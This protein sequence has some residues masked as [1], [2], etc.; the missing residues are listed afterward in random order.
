MELKLVNK[1]D[2]CFDYSNNS[3][4]YKYEYQGKYYE[5]LTNGN[6]I[7]ISPIKYCKCVDNN[8][9]CLYC[10]NK[11]IINNNLCIKCN[12]GFYEIEN[13]NNTNEY[14]ECYKDKIGYYLDM[15]ESIYKK[16]YFSF[17]KCEFKGSSTAHNCLECNINYPIEF[18]INN[19]YSN[20]YQ[21]SYYIII[22]S[23]NII[24][25]IVPMIVLVLMNIQY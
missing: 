18:K 22:I 24:I 21:C 20:C 11:T 15:N 14:K 19:N 16:W 5:N 10:S 1:T 25:F 4:L 17:K 3:I 8:E 9:K 23:M 7:N 13:D 12:H 2:I 6:L